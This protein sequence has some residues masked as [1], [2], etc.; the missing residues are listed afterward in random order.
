MLVFMCIVLIGQVTYIFV[1]CLCAD[2]NV[3]L[4]LVRK[5]ATGVKFRVSS[6]LLLL[7]YTEVSPLFMLIYLSFVSPLSPLFSL[8]S[9]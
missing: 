3:I 7:H 8:T 2:Q 5:R 4:S 6:I 1:M 9:L